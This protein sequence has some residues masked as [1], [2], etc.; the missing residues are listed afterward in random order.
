[1]PPRG[2]QGP[3]RGHGARRDG[4]FVPAEACKNIGIRMSPAELEC[5]ERREARRGEGGLGP[6]LRS[7][8]LQVEALRELLI[9]ERSTSAL[10]PSMRARLGWVLDELEVMADATIEVLVG[11]GARAGYRDD[12]AITLGLP[13]E[14]LIPVL[15]LLEREG[16]VLVRA[17]LPPLGSRAPAAPAPASVPERVLVV[18]QTRPPTGAAAARLARLGLTPP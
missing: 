12:L 6:A 5:A 3:L 9:T 7:A 11:T 13:E 17:G 8:L 1:M 15:A 10:A 2:N 4:A 14:D 18:A 16:L